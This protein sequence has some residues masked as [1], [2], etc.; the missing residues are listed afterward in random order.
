MSYEE[1]YLK[2]KNKYLALKK[3]IGGRLD[4]DLCSICQGVLDA[5]YE[6]TT[7]PCNHRFH[8]ECLDEN[9]KNGNNKCPLSA[10]SRA[11]I[12]LPGDNLR[13]KPLGPG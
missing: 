11:I 2:Y 1:K 12:V 6:V 9:F 8:T 4:V 7:T 10:L 13:S 5:S 3:L